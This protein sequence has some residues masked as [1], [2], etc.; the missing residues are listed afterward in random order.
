MENK[1][2]LKPPTSKLSLMKIIYMFFSN[3]DPGVPIRIWYLIE[4]I[5]NLHTN[6]HVQDKIMFMFLNPCL[7]LFEN[8]LNER[9]TWVDKP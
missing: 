4:S 6:H 5:S 1:K 9:E 2:C 7:S 3:E 8:G